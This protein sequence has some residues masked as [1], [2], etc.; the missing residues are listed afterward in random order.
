MGSPGTPSSTLAASVTL[1][2]VARTAP[3]R[4]APPALTSSSQ[5]QQLRPRLLWPWPLRLLLRP[6]QVLPGLLRHS[7]PVADHPL[8]DL[9]T[10][11]HQSFS[12]R[13]RRRKRVQC[14]VFS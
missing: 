5:G 8:L 13:P 11:D 10:V 14:R 3:L 9:H 1:A 4:S 12:R 2:P 6:L 7:L